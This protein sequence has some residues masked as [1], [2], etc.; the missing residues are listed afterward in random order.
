MAAKAQGA[1]EAVEMGEAVMAAAA[2]IEPP[3]FVPRSFG[4][5]SR[6]ALMD[7]PRR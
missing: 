7:N 4:V 3:A 5:A 6:R 2:A 1:V